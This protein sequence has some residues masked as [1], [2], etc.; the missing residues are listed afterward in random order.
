MRLHRIS[1]YYLIG[2]GLLFLAT[3]A[4]AQDNQTPTHRHAAVFAPLPAGQTFDERFLKIVRAEGYSTAVHVWG[5]GENDDGLSGLLEIAASDWGVLYIHTHGSRNARS[6]RRLQEGHHHP[7]G[8]ARGP[9]PRRRRGSGPEAV[10]RGDR[11]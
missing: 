10:S 9:Q 4:T 3:A 7:A 1:C 6:P 8:G 5:R 2:I 11:P